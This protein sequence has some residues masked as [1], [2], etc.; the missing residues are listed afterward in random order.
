ML[1]T[2]LACCLVLAA[3]A[4]AIV[5]TTDNAAA[6]ITWCRTCATISHPADSI[7]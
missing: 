1:R 6:G 3:L 7:P 2:F 5:S 4:L